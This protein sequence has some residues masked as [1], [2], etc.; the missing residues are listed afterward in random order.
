MQKRLVAISLITI[1]VLSMFVTAS[2][3]PQD[4]PPIKPRS[5]VIC[6]PVELYQCDED[7]CDET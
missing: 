4:P 6:D 1:L 5:I 3:G 2:A 7:Q